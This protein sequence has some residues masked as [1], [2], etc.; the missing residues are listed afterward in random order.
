MKRKA[1][2]F[3]L[4]SLF[5]FIDFQVNAQGSDIYTGGINIPVGQD[6][7]KNIRIIL[8]N[9]FWAKSVENNPGT[10]GVDGELATHSFDIGVRR[11]RATIYSQITPR[12]L[13]FTQIGINNQ[14]F[15]NG[16]APRQGPKKPQLFFHDAWTE[17][18]VISRVNPQNGERN[19]FS[20]ALGMGLHFW[21]GV[22]RFTNA[23]VVSF[24]T[25]DLPVFNFPNIE[26]SDQF[27]RQYGIYAKGKAGPLDY[28]FHLNKPFVSGSLANVNTE[29]AVDIP[30]DELA[31]GGYVAYEFLEPEGNLTPFKTETYIGTKKVFNLGA[32]FYH[33]PEASGVLNVSGDLERQDHTA[34][35]VDAFLDYPFGLRG[36][37]ITAYSVLYNYDY[38]TD[39]YRSV[40]I[41]NTAA[42][43]TSAPA[44]FEGN[45]SVD[46]FGNAEPLL[47]TGN[48]FLTQAGLLLPDNWL[49]SLGKL[50]PFGRV[51][52]KNLDYLDDSILNT[53]IGLN[54]FIE[55]HHAKITLQYGTRPLFFRQEGEI[56]SNERL[57]QWTLQTQIY[58]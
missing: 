40:G 54:W 58:I 9:Q 3:L 13:I 57:G 8:L 42:G 24:M 32:G 47:G 37:A 35:A 51:E 21:N 27:G 25:L 23:S 45:V 55:G 48:I 49:G 26:Q 53:D 46:G 41:M 16:G 12:F 1:I 39:Y 44:G 34:W 29:S 52:M 33:Q 31:L 28:R 15:V 5:F 10:V 43:Q 14:T 38:G 36:M 56:I 30:S 6:S 20:L 2:F 7:S 11:A 18:S 17:Y 4:L 50:Q 19:P 22:S